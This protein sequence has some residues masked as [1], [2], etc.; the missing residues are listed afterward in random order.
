MS[1]TVRISARARRDIAHALDW[2]LDQ[3]GDRQQ[4]VY[5]QLIEDALVR[6]GSDPEGAPARRRAE[7]G[8]GRWTL[9]IGR[10]GKP[11]RHLFAYRVRADG[12]VD[13]ARLLHDA[14]DL[15]RHFS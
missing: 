10:R 14:M 9:H 1:W 13:V 8:K 12:V 15:A 2:S 11:A 5:R 7:I 3:F 6:I 4:D